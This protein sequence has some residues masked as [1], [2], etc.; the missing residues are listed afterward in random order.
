MEILIKRL[1][2]E[3]KLPAYG[4]EAGPG[5]DLYIAKDITINPGE[6]VVVPTGVII[7]MPIGYVGYICG[8]NCMNFSDCLRVSMAVLDSGYREEVFVEV[9]NTGTDVRTYSV[10]EKIAQILV[11]QIVRSQLIEVEDL[12]N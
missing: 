5:I 6:K 4:R 3:V 9:I 10:G 1:N 11:H 7:A 12:G 2:E 8:A